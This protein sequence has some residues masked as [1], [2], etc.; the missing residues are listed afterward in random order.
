MSYKPS[1][2]QCWNGG[3]MPYNGNQLHQGAPVSNSISTPT[4]IPA[5]APVPYQVPQ[6]S[7]NVIRQYFDTVVHKVVKSSKPIHVTS[8]DTLQYLQQHSLRTNGPSSIPNSCSIELIING[9]CLGDWIANG[10]SS[11][12]HLRFR[13]NENVYI[14]T[15]NANNEYL[16]Q[17]TDGNWMIYKVFHI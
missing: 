13:G 2:F 9:R 5:P 6:I 11:I 8:Q 12:H 7:L 10:Y 16:I 15:Y 1:A 4:L 14:K 17:R 3:N